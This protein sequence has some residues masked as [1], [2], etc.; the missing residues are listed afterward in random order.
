ME[1]TVRR[2]LTLAAAAIVVAACTN[3]PAPSTTTTTSTSTSTTTTEPPLQLGV[4]VDG[5]TIHVG[6]FLPLSGSV[7]AIGSAVLEGQTAYW[8]YVNEELGGVAGRFTVEVAQVDTAYDPD[9]A[10]AELDRWR[11]DLLAVSSTIGSEV[12]AA[13]LG[14]GIPIMVGSQ[15]TSWGARNDAI[16]DLAVP[17]YRAQ[18]AALWW[19]PAGS[20]IGIVAPEGDYGDDC[21][22]GTGSEPA[23]LVRYPAGTTDFEEAVKQL[24]GIDAL[25]A[26]VTS[27]DLGRIIATWDLIGSRPPVYAT[28]PSFDRSL[29]DVLDSMPDDLFVAGAPPPYE[30]D[31]PGMRL[32]R[33]AMGETPVNRW[34]FLGYT[35]AATMHLLFEQ[36]IVDGSLTRDGVLSA[37]SRLADVD[38]GFGWGAAHFDGTLPVVPVTISVPDPD[39]VFGLRP[40]G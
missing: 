22:A 20:S 7:A 39:A 10:V 40:A 38:F 6:A 11:N 34:T 29:F 5:S 37:R 19:L 33:A 26:C 32:F 21:L 16:F 12:T 27:P 3:A 4:G 2:I 31:K 18:V 23:A 15:S 24:E 28:A 1:V 9:T 25:V 17:T 14:G 13:L 35:Q 36:A 8:R 30:S